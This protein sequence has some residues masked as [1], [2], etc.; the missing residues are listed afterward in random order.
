MLLNIELNASELLN[1]L[2][3]LNGENP[4]PPKNG[5]NPKPRKNGEKPNPPNR[6]KPPNQA[7]TGSV[8]SIAV[9]PAARAAAPIAL[10]FLNM[11]IH[12]SYDAWICQHGIQYCL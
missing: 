3:K 12:T 10:I 1:E 7:D 5:E 2:L 9:S 8:I 11:F 6:P 4:N